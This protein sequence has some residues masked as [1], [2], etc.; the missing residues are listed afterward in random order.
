[1]Q[2]GQRF[3]Y[4]RHPE[5]LLTAWQ[6]GNTQQRQHRWIVI[7]EIQK[8]PDLLDIV[9]LGIEQHGLRFAL[10]GSS[11]RKL[12]YGAA[13]LLAGRAFTFNLHP[14]SSLELGEHFDLE[15]ALCFGMLPKAVELRA[16][17]SDRRRFLESY[18]NTYLNEEIQAEG[19]VRKF[20]PFYHFL[21]VAAESNG[22]ILNFAKLARQVNVEPR[23]V[24][25]YFTLLADTLLGFFLPPFHRSVR[26][27][28]AV[29]PK[30]YFFDPGVIRAATRT[31]TDEARPSTYAFGRLFEHF[32][33]LEIIKANS[34]SERGYQFSYLRTMNKQ[35]TEIDLI[36]SRGRK[37][38]AIEIKS[39]LDPDITSIRKLARLSKKI[40]GCV[41]YLFCRTPVAAIVEGVHIVPWQRGV[42]ELFT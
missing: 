10:S 32:V 21:E 12:R 31:L 2:P 8:V 22:M 33:I 5:Q 7:D 14:F 42:V 1:M 3:H 4:T 25:R 40:D 30:F 28:Q 9:H 26:K 38:L 27:K 6:K 13:N 36:A 20:E 15:D 39:A 41:S 34:A 16:H 17:V 19:L 24:H 23:T 18:V 37:I 11:T 35:Q 29:S